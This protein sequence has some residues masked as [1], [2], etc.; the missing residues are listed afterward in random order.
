MEE[1]K[2]DLIVLSGN[3]MGEIS[4][5]IL[6]IGQKS[7]EEALL[8][9]KKIFKDDFYIEIMRHNQEDED[10][11]NNVLVEFSK[12]HNIKIVATNNNFYKEKS[13]ADAHDILLCIKEGEK[14]STPVG[15]GRG[16]RYGFNM[17]PG[18]RNWLTRLLCSSFLQ[19]HF[20]SCNIAKC[21]HYNFPSP[22]SI[23]Y[24]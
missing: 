11:V 2:D 6:N 22:P 8:W 5:K 19:R 24:V 21:S 20:H 10:L 23:F 7:A 9:W 16:F 18:R 3:L 17:P 15:R 13:E 1:Y 4:N 14:L 12:K